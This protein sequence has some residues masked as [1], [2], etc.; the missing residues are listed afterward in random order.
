VVQELRGEKIDI[1]TWDPD[2]AKFICNALAPADI[3]RV[4]VDE[5]N[6]SMEVVVPDDQ[7]SLAIGKRGQNVRL[8]SRLTGWRLDVVGETN[9]NTAL[10]D[11]YRS[12]L[13]LDGIGEKRA[14]DLYEADF[15]SVGDVAGASVEDLLAV[16][17]MTEAKAET[18]IDEAI[19]YVSERQDAEAPDTGMHKAAGKEPDGAIEEKA[20]ASPESP[21]SLSDPDSQTETQET[22]DHEKLNTASGDE[23]TETSQVEDVVEDDDREPETSKSADE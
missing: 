18:L 23:A 21:P 1:V 5:D 13:D 12:L 2:A 14:T 16:K 15:K 6:R 4:I 10:K 7:L 19:R 3:T 11:G 8:A 22:S 17:G 9:Y 20:E